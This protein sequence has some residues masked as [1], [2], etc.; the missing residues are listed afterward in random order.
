MRGIIKAISKK[1]DT[2]RCIFQT[3]RVKWKVREEDAAA[4][5]SSHRNLTLKIGKECEFWEVRQ[6]DSKGKVSYKLSLK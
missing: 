5:R 4:V 2:S 1:S 3:W 6:N